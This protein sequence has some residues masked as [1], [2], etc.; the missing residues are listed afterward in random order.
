MTPDDLRKLQGEMTG[1][2]WAMTTHTNDETLFGVVC[3]D[4]L[5]GGNMNQAN[6]RAIAM[7]PDLIA[8][9]LRLQAENEALRSC[10]G[11]IRN[12][13]AAIARAALRTPGT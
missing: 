3:L 12:D 11:I 2:P 6:A 9:V 5:I 4:D 1:G 13:T 7:T 8:E 10:A